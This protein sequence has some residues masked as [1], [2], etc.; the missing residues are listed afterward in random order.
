MQRTGAAVFIN[1]LPGSGKSTLARR[2]VEAHPG[3]F[4]LDVDVLRTSVGGWSE[5]F[6]GAGRIVRPVAQAIVRSVVGDGGTVVMP[7]LFPD[8][9]E[10]AEFATHARDAG[11]HVIHAMLDVPADECWRRLEVRRRS[12]QAAGGPSLG[13]VVGEALDRAGG[14]RHLEDLARMLEVVARGPVVAQRVDGADA[15]LALDGLT[16]LIA[17]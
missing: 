9:D 10:L 5:D 13:C 16:A 4:L 2:L 17:G 6:A 14:S 8:A 15:A 12:G 7:Q 11:G 3:W 1:G